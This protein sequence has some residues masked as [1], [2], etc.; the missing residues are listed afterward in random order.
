MNWKVAGR[1][2]QRFRRASESRGNA[3]ISSSQKKKKRMKKLNP[4]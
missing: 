2:V 3:E 1:R 4:F